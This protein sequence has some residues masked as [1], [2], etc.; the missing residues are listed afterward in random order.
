MIA[1]LTYLKDVVTLRLDAE[2]CTGCGTC[3][4]VCPQA[5]LARENGKVRIDS[6]DSCMEC[7]ACARNCPTGAIAVNAGVGCAAAVI[8]AALGR[9]SSS[10]CCI[11]E[12]PASADGT[13]PAA[14]DHR[15]S[16]CC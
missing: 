15:G 7:G 14:S 13:T 10:C 6:R 3:L 8:N 4:Q 9:K 1:Q 2:K 16:G 12:E 5:V 11:I